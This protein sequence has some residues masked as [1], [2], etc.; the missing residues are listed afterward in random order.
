MRARPGGRRAEPCAKCPGRAG[1]CALPAP[2][3]SWECPAGARWA[4]ARVARPG[5]LRARPARSHG[6][7]RRRRAAIYSECGGGKTRR[8]SLPARPPRACSGASGAAVTPPSPPALRGEG[9]RQEASPGLFRR[10]PHRKVG[11]PPR[12]RP[13]PNTHSLARAPLQPG[14]RAVRPPRRRPAQASR[15]SGGSWGA[16]LQSPRHQ[17]S[18]AQD[19]RPL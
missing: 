5:S 8:R 15:R 4:G 13:L 14:P 10:L 2:S 18:R 6:S 3:R 16:P 19:R 12:S 17:G 11:L 1:T 9:A 7:S